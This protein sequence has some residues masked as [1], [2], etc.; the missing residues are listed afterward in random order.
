M[1]VYFMFLVYVYQVDDVVL[2]Y[3]TTDYYMDSDVTGVAP[4]GCQ[5]VCVL[6]LCMRSTTLVKRVYEHEK[7]YAPD[8]VNDVYFLSF[9][10]D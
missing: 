4:V 8:I 3:R 2:W 10:Y 7:R 1:Y 6:W 9:N 5:Q